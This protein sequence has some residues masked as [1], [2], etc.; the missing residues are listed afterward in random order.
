M[1][2]Q[3]L[4][5]SVTLEL[6]QLLSVPY[7][8]GIVFLKAKLPKGDFSE[9]TKRVPIS[10]HTVTWNQTFTF[11]CKMTT[12]DSGELNPCICRVSV[13]KESQG[14]QSFEKLGAVDINL[15]EY[16]GAGTVDRR[17]LLRGDAKTG[18]RLDNSMLDVKVSLTLTQGDPCFKAPPL[19][20]TATSSDKTLNARPR[21]SFEADLAMTFGSLQLHD[22]SLGKRDNGTY[23]RTQAERRQMQR[24]NSSSLSSTRVDASCVVDELFS[25]S[26]SSLP[27][28]DESSRDKLQ[29]FIGK[30]GKASV[31]PAI[32]SRLRSSHPSLKK[33]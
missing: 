12:R 14:G 8:T 18:S 25:K 6:C 30:D 27:S 28:A 3:K 15:A 4:R 11:P 7:V 10:N 32:D 13:R 24:N 31:D 5:F 17:Y 26:S 29:L 23:P 21:S 33:D 2:K 19:P 9:E 16:A 1:P 20:Q 22:L